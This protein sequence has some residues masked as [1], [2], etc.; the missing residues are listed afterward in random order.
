MN[1][2]DSFSISSFRQI[3]SL[4]EEHDITLVQHL[5]TGRIYVQKRVSVYNIDVY[6]TLRDHPVKGTPAIF[7]ICEENGVLTVIEEYVSGSTLRSI[8]D[9]GNVFEETDAVE[10]VEKLCRIIKDLHS[11][12]PPIIHRDIKPSNIIVASNDSLWLLDMNAAKFYSV[13][14]AEDTSMLGTF[15]YA[16]PEQFGF[17]S[18]SVQTDIYSIGVLLCE[19]VTGH[20]PREVLP[21]SDLAKIILKCTHIDPKDR[22]QCAEDLLTALHDY[23]HNHDPEPL[24]TGIETDRR[25]TDSSASSRNTDSRRGGFQRVS[26][27]LSSSHTMAGGKVQSESSTYRANRIPGFRTGS[28]IKMIIA[29]IGYVSLFGIGL[30]LESKTSGLAFLWME[31]IGTVLC[32]LFVILFTCNYRNLWHYFHIDRIRSPLWRVAAVLL[33]DILVPLFIVIIIALAATIAGL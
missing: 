3:A 22:Y 1:P 29:I 24:L 27:P 20:L 12:V 16:A 31:R 33:V 32:G 5:F 26:D 10:M 4:D 19:M 25:R 21:N 17:G 6:R 9:D 14:K 23:L 13:D 28:P 18:S 7:D 30:T 15:G 11:L 8:L 2:A